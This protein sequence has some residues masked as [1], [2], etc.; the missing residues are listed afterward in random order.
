MNEP[1]KLTYRNLK[2]VPL[3]LLVAVAVFGFVATG[4]ALARSGSF[5]VG[6]T[7]DIDYIRIKHRKSTINN[8]N[9]GALHEGKTYHDSDSASRVAFGGGLVAG[10]RLNLGETGAFYVSAEVDGQLDARSVSGTLPGQGDT[11]TDHRQSGAS[12]PDDWNL[13]RKYSYGATIKLGRV[14]EFLGSG[15]SVYVLGGARRLRTRLKVD[16]LGCPT[17]DRLCTSSD[18][19]RPGSYSQNNSLWGWTAGAGME[20]MLA[21]RVGI[22]GEIRHARYEKVKRIDVLKTLRV[23]ASN[24]QNETSFSL[25]AVVYF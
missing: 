13:E 11:A 21:D 7:S 1:Q 25:S 22:R 9:T 15:S 24:E 5:Y 20:K 23:P 14:A 3:L 4:D 19:Y 6:F 12:W 10:Y 8:P 17:F 2:T 18:Q 16:Y